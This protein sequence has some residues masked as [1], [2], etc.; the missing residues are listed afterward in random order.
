ML[1][2][3]DKSCDV[4]VER[5][6]YLYI[7]EEALIIQSKRIFVMDSKLSCDVIVDCEKKDTL[8]MMKK[9][10]SIIVSDKQCFIN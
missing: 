8:F 3:I 5:Q 7:Y 9:M 2:E 10:N 4:I 1:I 6:I